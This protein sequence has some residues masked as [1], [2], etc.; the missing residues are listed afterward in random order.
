MKFIGYISNLLSFFNDRRIINNI[1]QM[2]QKMIENKTTRLSKITDNKREYNRYKS[3]L[4][5][6]LKSI[7]DNKKISS[8]AVRTLPKL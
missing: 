8:C 5:G 1:E 6:S 2:I 7:L 3:L 4:D